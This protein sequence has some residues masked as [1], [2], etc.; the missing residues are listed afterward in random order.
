MRR[1]GDYAFPAWQ[2]DAHGRVLATL[3]YVIRVARS[4]GLS[5][6]RLAEVFELRLGLT[7]DRRVRD[8]LRD[9]NVER[10]L[11]VVRGAAAQAA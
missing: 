4:L 3:P 5:D 1:G 10:V 7:A 9:G 8:S 6:E 11:T 2:F